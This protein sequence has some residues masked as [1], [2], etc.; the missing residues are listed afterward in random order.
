MLF[1]PDLDPLATSDQPRSFILLSAL[2]CGSLEVCCVAMT[3]CD[4]LSIGYVYHT[5]QF[6]LP[7]HVNGGECL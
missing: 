7:S 3:S 6:P 5:S 4:G 2:Y 1:D